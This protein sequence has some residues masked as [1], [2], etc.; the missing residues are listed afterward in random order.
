MGRFP[1]RLSCD[2]L[3][4]SRDDACWGSCDKMLPLL[5]GPVSLTIFFT[6]G[7]ADD[8][9]TVGR[10]GCFP[11]RAKGAVDDVEGVENAAVFGRLCDDAVDTL[12]VDRVLERT[13][14]AV[15]RSGAAALFGTEDA[16]EPATDA[17]DRDGT[18]VLDDFSFLGICARLGSLMIVPSSSF[19]L[20]EMP[21]YRPLRSTSSSTSTP[22]CSAIWRGV[23]S[24]SAMCSLA[25]CMSVNSSPT[26]SA[27]ALR[28]LLLDLVV[29]RSNTLPKY[30]PPSECIH[31]PL[32]F[33]MP[34]TISLIMSSLSTTSSFFPGGRASSSHRWRHRHKSCWMDRRQSV[35]ELTITA[36]HTILHV[37]SPRFTSEHTRAKSLAF[38][39]RSARVSGRT[40]DLSRV[41][42]AAM[43]SS[44]ADGMASQCPLG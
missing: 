16:A 38:P 21:V 33:R 43:A 12:G 28:L 26:F 7:G 39:L 23:S 18:A 29:S 20:R 40:M 8:V 34:L 19:A 44:S 31:M 22:Y 11:A 10:A 41:T 36:Q 13:G 35:G 27:S 2:G 30:F 6:F 1:A 37:R 9:D 42:R 24:S 3:R 4:E 15:A 5:L 32:S 14:A 17:V 25:E